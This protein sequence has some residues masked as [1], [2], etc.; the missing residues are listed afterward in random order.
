MRPLWLV[1]WAIRVC[2][3]VVLYTS[4]LGR[5]SR[6]RGRGR[7]ARS[8]GTGANTRSI[9]GRCSR[10]RRGSRSRRFRWCRTATGRT[11]S[12]GGGR[13]RS[14]RF[15]VGPRISP[16]AYG[17]ESVGAALSIYAVKLLLPL[18][19]FLRFPGLLFFS[20]LA[21][22]ALNVFANLV[23]P[24]FLCKSLPLFLITLLFLD[25]LTQFLFDTLSLLFQLP[26]STL[27]V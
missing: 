7:F 9:R 25:F 3:I 17:R 2:F 21:G 24:F 19:F 20:Q 22:S 11:G 23:C 4:L 26:L 13:A 10:R 1:V 16:L 14:R 15:A 5:T 12:R 27:A 18:F 8:R 6:R